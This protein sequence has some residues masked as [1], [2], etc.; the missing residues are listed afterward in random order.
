MTKP[1]LDQWV[2]GGK[3]LALLSYLQLVSRPGHRTLLRDKIRQL[4]AKAG[5][6][7]NIQRKILSM[8][9]PPRKAPFLV[10]KGRRV[11]D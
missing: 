2:H 6:S 10:K 9:E 11:Q 1:T 5:Y 7:P 3:A 8:H 4:L